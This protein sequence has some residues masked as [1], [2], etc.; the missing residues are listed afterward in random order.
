MI[1]AVGNPTPIPGPSRRSAGCLAVLA[2]AGESTCS[3]AGSSSQPSRSHRD[4]G[5]ADRRRSPS[6]LAT[7]T[8]PSRRS[9]VMYMV[10]T[11]RRH[12]RRR[13]AAASPRSALA[14]PAKSGGRGQA[15]LSLCALRA[16]WATNFREEHGELCNRETVL[17][18]CAACRANKAQ[19][20]WRST[21][22]RMA[23]RFGRRFWHRLCRQIYFTMSSGRDWVQIGGARP[24]W[25]DD[26]NGASVT[27]DGATRPLAHPAPCAVADAGY[28]GFDVELG[29]VAAPGLIA[30]TVKGV[31][32]VRGGARQR[33]PWLPIV[34]HT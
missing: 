12:R 5:P 3:S 11:E 31:A 21:L 34:C 32:V 19:L 1:A 15:P 28:R 13:S 29:A 7:S 25:C 16:S 14:T 18:L 26:N 6:E 27:A 10:A 2:P 22:L 20:V 17:R 33:V 8:N 23:R 4:H 24:D 30:R 9:V